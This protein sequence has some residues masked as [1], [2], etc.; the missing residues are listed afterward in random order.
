MADGGII[1][2]LL[3]QI[4]VDSKGVEQGATQAVQKTATALKSAV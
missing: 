3:I 2:K 1:E 4:G